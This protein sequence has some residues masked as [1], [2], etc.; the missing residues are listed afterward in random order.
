MDMEN[1]VYII[2]N[3]KQTPNPEH[4]ERF[5]PTKTVYEWAETIT[6]CF[7]FVV[8]LFTFAV[9]VV[10]VKGP[11]MNDTLFEGERLVSTNYFTPKYK[12][13]VVITQPNNLM[14]PLIKRVI[15]TEGQTVNIDF[16]KGDVFVD[17]VMLDEKYSKDP[18]TVKGDIDFPQ[19]V[20]KGRVFV[21]GDNRN[22]SLDSRYK[23]IGMIDARYIFGKAV[24]RL[25]P[26]NRVGKLN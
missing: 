13:I 15:A 10:G 1:E 14:V 23:E 5:S 6:W 8:F 20:P 22:R 24:F 12:D 7:V 18:T 21:M 25:F 4:N 16:E 3:E 26:F 17:G 19:V 2:D 9:R 11:S